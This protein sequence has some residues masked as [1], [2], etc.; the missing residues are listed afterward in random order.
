MSMH[1][2]Q[3]ISQKVTYWFKVVSLGVIFGFGLQ[4]AQAWVGPTMTPPNGNISLRQYVSDCTQFAINGWKNKNECL[5]DGRWHLVQSTMGVANYDLIESIKAGVEVRVV[6]T[7]L[8]NATTNRTCASAIIIGGY[9]LCNESVHYGGS[10]LDN[11]PADDPRTQ[12][13]EKDLFSFSGSNP[14]PH[15]TWG[16]IGSGII[17][18]DGHVR[19][20]GIVPQTDGAKSYTYLRAGIGSVQ[21]LKWLVRY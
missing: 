7:N 10:V 21:N 9:A 1:K 15:Q 3:S 12:I 5:T 13:N 19:S 17:R 2:Q 18:S 16:S 4:F 11:I 8:S 20:A 14:Q 6:Y